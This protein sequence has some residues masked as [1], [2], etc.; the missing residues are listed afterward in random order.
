MA[1][2]ATRARP[3]NLTAALAA[4][5]I[6]ELVLNRLA[7]R[8]FLP[9]STISGAAAGS[10]GAH[11]VAAS[12]PLLFHLTG[13]LA[14]VVLPAALVGLLRRG[15]LFPRGMRFSVVVIGLAFWLL[16]AYAV[17]FGI[18]PGRF[19]PHV[20]FFFGLLSLLVALASLGADILPRVKAGIVLFATPG[21]LQAAA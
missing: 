19:F 15:E 2:A 11:L 10:R 21:V 3:G 1:I 18:V 8:L 6:L 4:F 17:V 9:Q 16:C 20:E 12:G 5:A 13:V 7:N 14:L